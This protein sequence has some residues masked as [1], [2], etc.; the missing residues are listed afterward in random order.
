VIDAFLRAFAN[1]KWLRFS[2][3]T[4]EIATKSVTRPGG[5]EY[6]VADRFK[7]LL[8]D[9]EIDDALA[10]ATAELFSKWRNSVVHHADRNNRLTPEAKGKLIDA[11][12]HFRQ[13]YSHLD[14]ELAIRNFESKSVPV[15]KE[16]TTLIA[17]MMNTC[18]LMDEAAV[19]RAAPDSESLAKV[20]E[21]L[22]RARLGYGTDGSE[23]W[24]HLAAS[25]RGDEKEKLTLLRKVL[26]S[27]GLTPTTKAISPPLPD[28]FCA[29][30]ATLSLD[31]LAERFDIHRKH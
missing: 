5:I 16:V 1:E 19:R 20:T 17:I 15:A 21:E 28:S 13:K 14:I 23:H 24:K 31:Q 22:L 25:W 29:N 7:A 11:K 12:T 2:V 9:L 3:T 8:E 18:R 10:I 27:I 6:S 26:P 4:I 30:L